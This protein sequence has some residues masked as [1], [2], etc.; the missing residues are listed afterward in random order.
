MTT[1]VLQVGLLVE[2]AAQLNVLRHLVH[3]S[4]HKVA[5][6]LLLDDFGQ[7][8]E[9]LAGLLVDA[10][11]IILPQE[12]DCGAAVDGWLEQLTQPVMIDDGKHSHPGDEG[13]DAWRRRVLKKLQQLQGAINLAQHPAAVAE[14]IWVLAASTGGPEA[15]RDFFKAL[16]DKLDIGFVYVQHMNVGFEQSLVDMLNRN[17]AYPAYP[18]A[19]GDVLKAGATAIIA[20]D[21]WMDFFSN[22]TVTARSESWPGCYSPSIDQVFANMARCFGARCNVIVFSGMGNDGA[23]GA[24]LIY[25]QGGQVW[26]QDPSSCTVASMPDMV[27][28]SEVVSVVATPAELAERLGE[29]MQPQHLQS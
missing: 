29:Y 18:L 28:A 21:Q 22:G 1:R 9:R 14:N 27:I 6:T 20:N 16:P 5:V 13:Y 23:N 4:G 26:A 17:S 19:D 10:W 3:E 15:V 11:L 8:R 2:S 12:G 7:Q 25:Q 24:R